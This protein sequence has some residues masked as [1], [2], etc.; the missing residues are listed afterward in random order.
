MASALFMFLA[1]WFLYLAARHAAPEEERRDAASTAV[2]VTGGALGLFI[3]AHEAVPDLAT[4]AASCAAFAALSQ[5]A[6]RPLA[7]GIA[8]GITLGIAFLST[9]PVA[10]GA[11]M[12]NQP[13][14]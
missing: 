14:A 4:L 8:F 2:L 12:G 13:P 9:G 3:H 5:A 7:A 1:L 10:P 11:S 6:R